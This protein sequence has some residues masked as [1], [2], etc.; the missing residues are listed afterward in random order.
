M[1]NGNNS[2]NDG[3]ATTATTTKTH[4]GT[5]ATLAGWELFENQINS[6]R[7]EKKSFHCQPA[8]QLKH[9]FR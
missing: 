3:K 6:G 8:G 7:I 2:G 9:G 1:D 5:V 4:H